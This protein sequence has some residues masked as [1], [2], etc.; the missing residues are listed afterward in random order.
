MERV[1]EMMR[2]AVT[3]RVFPGAVLWIHFRGATVFHEGFGLASLIPEVVPATRDTVYDLASLTKAIVTST[4]AAILV[5]HSKVSLDDPAVRYIPTFTGG[6]KDSIRVAHLLSHSSGLPAWR[7]LFERI[8]PAEV[9]TPMGKIRLLEEAIREP[10]VYGTGTKSVY[11]DLGF[12]LMGHL[13]EVATGVAL[14]DLA[15]QSVFEAMGIKGMF[16]LPLGSE[17]RA[18]I[19]ATHLI[20][21]TED[22][23][24]RGKMLHGAVHDENAYAMGGV[25]GHAGLFGTAAEVGRFALSL[26]EILEGKSALLSVDLLRQFTSRTTTV[27]ASS[28]GLGWDTPS[29][30]SSSGHRLSPSAFGHLGYTGTSLW[31]D[32][33]NELVIVLLSN[34]VHP[35][36]RNDKIKVFRPIV[37][38]QI[39]ESLGL[40]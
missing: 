5:D 6:G 19:L 2:R 38:D 15:R 11:S 34:R 25:S 1:Q 10:L 17:E 20:A 9:G 18:R 14:N 12:I 40:C 26:L 7:P 22:C 37:H 13:L 21:A 8:E 30:P 32:P 4:C 35:T 33:E 27:P 39:A 24:W 31:I 16:Y 29:E 23:P 28:W 36:S 3:E